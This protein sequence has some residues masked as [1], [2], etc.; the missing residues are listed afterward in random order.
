MDTEK[1]TFKCFSGEKTIKLS[2]INDGYPDCKDGSDE[3][4]TSTFINGS[5]Y[6]QNKGYIAT[7]IQKWS[8]GDGVCDCCDG[9]DEAFNSHANCPNTCAELEAQRIQL[10]NKLNSIYS[11]GFAT[12]LKRIETGKEKLSS[13]RKKKFELQ[14]LIK[15]LEDDKKRVEAAKALPDPT[16]IPISTPEP[17]PTP[18][19]TPET[20][21][22]DTEEKIQAL[23]K[24]I[25]ELRVL[26]G[27]G[28]PGATEELK[29]AKD[30]LDLLLEKQS[31][32]EAKKEASNTQSDDVPT[33]SSNNFEKDDEESEIYAENEEEPGAKLLGEAI[34]AENPEEVKEEPKE[35][36]DEEPLWKTIIRAIW[37]Y[38]FYVP[39]V[40]SSLEEGIRQKTLDDL[41]EKLRKARDSLREQEKLS[42]LDDKTDPAF[43]P[44]IGSKFKTD[45]GDFEYEVMKELKQ[46]YNSYGRYKETEGKIQKFKDGQHCWITQAGRKTDME[47]VCWNKDMLVSVIESDQC[48]H[49]AVFATPSACGDKED[50]SKLDVG[51]LKRIADKVNAKL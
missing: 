19:I 46:S 35:K 45:D 26:E 15:K 6:C 9:S 38:T 22:D 23:N 30:E 42:D 39:D 44:I 1:S 31:E 5:F 34:K 51:Q 16:P 24:R 43:V 37:Q 3:P 33:K 14:S 49:K 10:Y 32:A 48:Y 47:L 20:I 17:I 21:K 13:A 41:D 36:A 29:Q 50:L 25:D 8:V 4:G 2:Q 12:Y 40:R 28:Y 18:E 7:T 11:E 27:E